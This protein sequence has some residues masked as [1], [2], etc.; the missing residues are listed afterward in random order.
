LIEWHD[1]LRRL[2]HELKEFAKINA[3]TDEGESSSAAINLA[4]HLYLAHSAPSRQFAEICARGEMLSKERLAAE[5]SKCS[6][7]CAEA[8]LGTT[9]SVFFYVAPFRYPRTCFGLLFSATLELAHRGTGSASPF[10]SGGLVKTFNRIDDAETP[11]EFLL[12]HELPVPEHRQYLRLSMNTL[13]GKPMHYV[14]GADPKLSGPIGLTPRDPRCDERIWTHEVRIAGS[15]TLRNEHL[16]A[17]FGVQGRIASDSKVGQFFEWCLG[18]GIDIIEF[19]TPRDGAFD[20][21]RTECVAYITR[22]LGSTGN[23]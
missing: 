18:K 16:Q 9:N 15:I 12:R 19:E 11:R 13:F 22:K 5:G 20:A 4:D 17:V 6:S 10:D 8:K 1:N 21:L 23:A 3:I 2:C 7:G 14:E